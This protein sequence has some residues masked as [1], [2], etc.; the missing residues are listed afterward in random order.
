[1]TSRAEAAARLD[2]LLRRS[3]EMRE[4]SGVV[5]T[6]SNHRG[7]IYEGAFGARQLGGAEP[8]TRLPC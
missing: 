4:V 6:A 3:V 8:M 5:A 7:V 2:E 1:M